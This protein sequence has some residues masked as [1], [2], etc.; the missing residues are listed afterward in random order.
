MADYAVAVPRNDENEKQEIRFVYSI[1]PVLGGDNN[2]EGTVTTIKRFIG[3][4]N[5]KV[6][7][8]LK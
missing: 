8:Q 7:E 1:Q 6:N 5:E 3:H 2:W 4:A